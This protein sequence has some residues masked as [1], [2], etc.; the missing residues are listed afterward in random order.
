MKKAVQF[1]PAIPSG[2]DPRTVE[3]QDQT[4]VCACSQEPD[5]TVKTDNNQ[6]A[7]HGAV[8]KH[9]VEM[10]HVGKLLSQEQE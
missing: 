6:T 4:L 10:P 5:L 7:M 3:V 8:D 2:T 1:F 9:T